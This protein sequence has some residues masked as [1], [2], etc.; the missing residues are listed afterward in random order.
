M[1]KIGIIDTM[2][3]KGLE[4]L[5]SKKNF[6]FELITDLSRENLLKILPKFDG[7]TLRRG[8]LDSEILSKCKNLK[9]ISRHGVGYDNVDT[10]FLKENNIS[11]LVTHNSTSTSPAEH[12]MFMILNIY[13]GREM[14]D[15]MVR[16][17]N[18]YKAIHLKID[19]NFELFNKTIL[20]IGCG[21]IGRKLIKKCLG[22][23]MKVQV[24]DPY[25]EENII[26]S[27]GA[28]KISDL[29]QGLKNLDILSLCVPLN[30][31][32]KNMISI[33]ELSLMKKTA[34]LINAARGGVVNENDLN[35]ALNE[36]LI[37]FAGVDVFETEP[38]DKNN[39]LLT[40]KRVIL[41][42]HAATFTKEC[43]ENMSEETV[44]NIIDF[45]EKKIEPT[46]VVQL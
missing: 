46:K 10:K 6:S 17:G 15:T 38:P 24:Y 1:F 23:D 42:P 41:S 36:N 7:V 27:L 3:E 39:P 30:D 4:L 22:F 29:N 28:N 8:R 32:T 14:F 5:K 35:K 18:F 33:K 13:K 21:R 9:V 40:N 11:L 19:D 31:E 16:E 20:I 2:N 44:Q 26:K 12:I 43:L 34:I 45:F 37:S 25:V